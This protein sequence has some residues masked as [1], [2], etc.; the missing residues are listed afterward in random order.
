MSDRARHR[1]LYRR[2]PIVACEPGCSDCCGP[3]PISPYEAERLGVPG[4]VTT[5]V[6]E[7]TATCAF[8]ID[9]R[10]SVYERRPY[11]CRLYGTTPVAAC[12]RG[13]TPKAGPMPVAEAVE[14]TEAFEA[15]CP[16]GWAEARREAVTRIVAR[17]G[18]AGEL[19]ALERAQ[20][21]ARSV[22]EGPHAGDAIA[23]ARDRAGTGAD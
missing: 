13:C 6:H 4:A 17:D 7:G 21:L 15:G 20:R 22:A 3:A 11:V 1:R 16:P 18:T 8:L 19:A 2:I 14:L 9:G 10:C 12:P 23:D 5:P